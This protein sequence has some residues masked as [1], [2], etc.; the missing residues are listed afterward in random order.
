MV[1][2]IK[3]PHAVQSRAT[4]FST[5]GLRRDRDYFIEN[6]S[7]LIASGMGVID[8]LNA[9]NADIKS[10]RM[11][12]LILSMRDEIESGS[13]IW[14]ALERA[15]LFPAHSISL[16][17]IGEESGRLSENLQVVSIEQEKD[18]SFRSKIRAA[19]MY[20]LFVLG[21]TLVFGIG[22]AFFIL[23]KLALVFSQLNIEL[24]TITRIIIGAGVFLGEHGAIVLPIAS[25]AI[26]GIIYIVFFFPKTKRVGQHILFMIPGVKRLI[27]ESELARFG[28]LLGTLLDA[29]LPVT[30]ALA[31]LSQSSS[32]P[33]YDRFYR[34]LAARIEEG[35]SFQRCFATYKRVNRMIPTPVQQLIMTGERSGNLPEILK[36]IGQ[37]YEAKT[38]ATTKNLTV[39]LEPILLVVV[40]LGVISVALAVIMPIYKLIGGLETS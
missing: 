32:F 36:K 24:P 19:M 30:Q 10:K 11:R 5:F 27:Q 40:W 38:D 29:G 18:R 1:R 25:L 16:I 17:R 20:P 14:R 28:Y 9:V 23:P 39:I 7:T 3:K 13:P 22:I 26:G 15:R 37:T 33:N 12:M 2:M 34:Y 31:S 21:L 35:N 6:A 4:F 8:A